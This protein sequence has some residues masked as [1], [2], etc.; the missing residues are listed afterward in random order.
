MIIII[1]MIIMIIIMII[2]I[3]I[4]IITP[5]PP[6]LKSDFVGLSVYEEDNRRLGPSPYPH[7]NEI[8][9]P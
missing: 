3:I 5:F 6:S 1:I 8:F 4:I 9:P 2:M 7:L